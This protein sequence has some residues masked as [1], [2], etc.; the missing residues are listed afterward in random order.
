MQ[1]GDFYCGL[2]SFWVTL[3]A[4]SIVGDKFRSSFQL[5]GAIVIA[6]LTTWNMHSF[7]AFLLPVAIGVTVLLFSWYVDYRK[8]R[9]MRYPR[10]YYT[11]YMPLGLILVSIGLISYAFLQ[12]EQ[13]Y[14]I[15]H[16]L[17]HMIIALS[18]V[19]LLPDTKRGEN[20]NPFVPSPNY[21]RLSFCRVFHRSQTPIASD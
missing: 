16:S 14:K 20:S 12:T 6:L 19:F 13:N 10:S 15:V 11:R 4:M 5:T 17:W 3:L 18:V 7:V 1:F 8:L 9:T 21:C 2:M